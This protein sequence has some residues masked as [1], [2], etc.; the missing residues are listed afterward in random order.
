MIGTL[1][2]TLCL[3]S[4]PEKASFFQRH[5]TNTNQV[6]ILTARIDSLEK[7]IEKLEGIIGTSIDSLDEFNERTITAIFLLAQRIEYESK[8]NQSDQNLVD[9]LFA[10]RIAESRGVVKIS[11]G[12]IFREEWS[13]KVDRSSPDIKRRKNKAITLWNAFKGIK[14]EPLIRQTWKLYPDG[15]YRLDKSEK[16]KKGD[17]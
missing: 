9:Y 6:E 16:Y 5:F 1:I 4:T 7:R 17:L 2:V 3:I 14:P 8:L 15:K 10:K 11:D 13:E 12:D